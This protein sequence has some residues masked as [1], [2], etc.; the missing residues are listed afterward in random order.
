MVDDFS[1]YNQQLDAQRDDETTGLTSRQ[2]NPSLQLISAH[3]P[4]A[5][6]DTNSSDTINVVSNSNNSTSSS[7]TSDHHTDLTRSNNSNN[8]LHQL[9]QYTQSNQHNQLQERQANYF[10]IETNS[11]YSTTT[12]N[13][14]H[15]H[16]IPVSNSLTSQPT[17]L[18]SSTKLE[19]QN[20]SQQS[21][22]MNTDTPQHS[23][24]IPTAHGSEQ[25]IHYS[26]PNAKNLLDSSRSNVA[27]NFSHDLLQQ[28]SQNHQTT[29]HQP[30][31][32]SD[33]KHHLSNSFEIDSG[34]LMQSA[35]V[36]MNMWKSTMNLNHFKHPV[37]AEH[38]FLPNPDLN[39]FPGWPHGNNLGHQPSSMTHHIIDSQHL[40]GYSQH[41]RSLPIPSQDLMGN[42]IKG[43]SPAEQASFMLN[44]I[45]H[46][47]ST[48]QNSSS[49]HQTT[50]PLDNLNL[51]PS[52]PLDHSAS[53]NLSM[54]DNQ[55]YNSSRNETRSHPNAIKSS[56]MV[57]DRSVHLSL[58]NHQSN[59]AYHNPEHTNLQ[60]TTSHHVAGTSS[61]ASS[62]S[63]HSKNV[64]SF[65]CSTCKEVF[66]LRTVYQSHL[67]THSQ[68]KG[69]TMKHQLS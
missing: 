62:S 7:S 13:S 12:G 48:S 30:S 15:S 31:D 35:A 32:N 51:R 42:S 65:T 1:Q 5:H 17:T 14:H 43:Q 29:I 59:I 8:N 55:F 33:P 27:L 3:E 4:T 49:N 6:L 67:K 23:N 10:A 11:Q 37:I 40:I 63:L 34:S 24:V 36:G 38:N 16:F 28:S 39:P 68:D 20:P 50:Q 18:T 47:A 57:A 64:G 58:A 69:K 46:Q 25:Q 52:H 41:Q 22:N 26:S 66:S 44:S 54:N 45:N 60:P 19:I 53:Y 56:F 21:G 61:G 2:M 9:E